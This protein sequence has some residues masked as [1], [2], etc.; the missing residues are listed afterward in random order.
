[1]SVFHPFR[2]L[3]GSVCFRPKADTS[4]RLT[5]WPRSDE[6][7]P[8]PR[9]L[10][11]G[12]GAIDAMVGSIFLQP[13]HHRGAE[14]GAGLPEQVSQFDFKG[15]GLLRDQV[16]AAFEAHS[17]RRRS[18]QSC[19]DFE[20]VRNICAR[21]LHGAAANEKHAEKAFGTNIHALSLAASTGVD[22]G[23]VPPIAD[24][25]LRV[26]FPPIADIRPN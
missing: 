13:R 12:Y 14:A 15:R 8:E 16:A 17:A 4:A 11:V 7:R 3:G 25:R 19:R 24:M 5:D 21:V 6:D 22:K 2:T 20:H 10:S 9:T 26:R 23:G 18:H 1:M